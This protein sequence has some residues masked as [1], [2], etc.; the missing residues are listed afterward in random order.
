[1][2]IGLQLEDGRHRRRHPDRPSLPAAVGGDGGAT[3]PLRHRRGRLRG[4]V[5]PGRGPPPDRGVDRRGLRAF[6]SPAPGGVMR[7]PTLVRMAVFFATTVAAWGVLTVGMDQ[8]SPD[9]LQPRQVA[10]RDYE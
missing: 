8:E 2:P 10:L 3:D 7:R 9:D 1:N 6:R 5:E 4:V